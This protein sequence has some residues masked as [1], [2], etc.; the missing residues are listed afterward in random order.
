MMLRSGGWKNGILDAEDDQMLR[1]AP[2]LRQEPQLGTVGTLE[3]TAYCTSIREQMSKPSPTPDTATL[4][5]SRRETLASSLED[6]LLE[7]E[8][9]E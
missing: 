9:N 2:H 1:M 8:T 4:F 6:T 7:K 3:R 5:Q